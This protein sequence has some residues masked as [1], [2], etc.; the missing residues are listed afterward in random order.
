[1]NDHDVG[2]DRLLDLAGAVCNKTASKNDYSELDAILSADADSCRHYLR[3]CRMHVALQ[4]E[5]RA[6]RAARKLCERIDAPLDDVESNVTI[7]TDSRTS[8]AHAAHSIPI[9]L[10]TAP[11]HATTG[12][13]SSG[14]PVAYVIATVIFAVGLMI[15]AVVHVSQPENLVRPSTPLPSPLSTLPSSAVARI[16]G[17]FDCVLNN[18][19]CRM[20]NA[21]LKT[22]IH[23]S[24]FINQHSLVHL[25]D[26]LALKSGLLELTYDTGA[27][28]ILQGP[29]TYE[30][31]SPSGGY[32]SIGKLTARLEKKVVSG[33]WSVASGQ[34]SASHQPLATDRSPN[35]QSLIPNPAFAVRTPTALV[36][37]LGTEFGVE[38]NGTGQTTSHVFQGT[39]EM[40]AISGNGKPVGEAMA[41][42]ASQSARVDLDGENRR[43]VAV[44]GVQRPVF[45]RKFP[46]PTIKVLD[47]VD[48]VAGGDGYS[49]RRNR[50]I[51][52]TDGRPT[53]KAWTD[54]RPSTA[55]GMY[56]RAQGL[57][58]VD[59][60][61]VPDSR[62]G[63]VQLDS[64]GHEFLFDRLPQ[65]LP[66]T[67][68]H[69]WA[70]GAIPV[71]S[72]FVGP[73]K[74]SADFT[75]KYE[76]DVL[77][78]TQDLDGNN[79][80]DIVAHE[81]TPRNIRVANGKMTILDTSGGLDYI[82]SQPANAGT[83]WQN[84]FASGD[85]TAEFSAKVLTSVEDET[86]QHGASQFVTQ[87][88]RY[89]TMLLGA[90]KT[91]AI[92]AGYEYTNLS[93]ADNTDAFHTFRV[94]RQGSAYY[95]WRDGVLIGDGLTMDPAGS[96]MHFGDGGGWINGST[97]VDY[98]RLQNGAFAP[99]PKPSDVARPS[100]LDGKHAGLVSAKSGEI[101]Y[102]PAGHGVLWLP[103][104]KGVTFD[105]DAIRRAN[106]G[107]KLV[108]FQAVGGNCEDDP[109]GKHLAD[110]WV[111]VDG[112]VR[113]RRREI[114]RYNGAIP[115]VVFIDGKDRFLTLAAT[116]GGDGTKGDFIVFGDPRIELLASP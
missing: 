64:A 36:T 88:G 74:D 50:G 41:L 116:D 71:P 47:L 52:I 55:H 75:Y 97:A 59:G 5:V 67:E 8:E 82:G 27:R 112:Q 6:D 70:G 38:V 106:P 62:T 14:W 39:V 19:Q 10:I 31:E 9:S 94:A 7:S 11:L 100:S 56:R 1:M 69:V 109:A 45:I 66:L 84:E 105:L 104:N 65:S 72:G 30:V 28:V 37:D 42:H 13:F 86:G 53:D 24:S 78:S 95:L 33:Q 63:R 3:Y 29:V 85:Y 20:L 61:F 58:L 90:A 87:N 101:D 99:P 46:Q 48:V 60:V 114:N 81:S 110:V 91:A 43:I 108:R 107:C 54:E 18:D 96:K 21:E 40:K 16:T 44:P 12:Y 15:G 23:H 68:F 92:T 17:M 25:G 113:F 49:G 89:D 98:V 115:V 76:M 34:T 73:T 35:P 80:P 51:D 79:T 111:F 93:T 83:I 22:D 26:C 77:P 2:S 57:P 32:L 103:P 102:S 4:F